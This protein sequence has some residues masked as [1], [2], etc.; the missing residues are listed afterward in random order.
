MLQAR[1]K[2][3]GCAWLRKN[4]DVMAQLRVLRVNDDWEQFWKNPATQN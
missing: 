4:A 1:L 2:L 3:A